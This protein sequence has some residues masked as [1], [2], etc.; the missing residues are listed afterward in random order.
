MGLVW[1]PFTT[2][3]CRTKSRPSRS[4]VVTLPTS[5]FAPL[6]GCMSIQSHGEAGLSTAAGTPTWN[7]TPTQTAAGCFC[8]LNRE[9]FCRRQASTVKLLQKNAFDIISFPECS[10]ICHGNPGGFFHKATAANSTLQFLRTLNDFLHQLFFKNIN[11]IKHPK[12]YFLKMHDYIEKLMRQVA[13]SICL[14]CRCINHR[15]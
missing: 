14:S 7:G 6:T 11:R 5:R 1:K 12:Y 9:W 2:W 8:V 15:R 13:L 10:L 4:R 3:F